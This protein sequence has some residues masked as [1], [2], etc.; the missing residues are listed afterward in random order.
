M[1]G[2]IRQWFAFQL[3]L[4]RRLR[5]PFKFVTFKLFTSLQLQPIVL[6][7]T[8]QRRRR[9]QRVWMRVLESFRMTDSDGRT[10]VA[11]AADPPPNQIRRLTPETR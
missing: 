5:P 10:R 3:A 7:V 6:F 11:V 8:T 1:A 2:R 9:A 4:E